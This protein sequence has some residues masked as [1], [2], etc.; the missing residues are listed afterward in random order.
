MIPTAAI[1][2]SNWTSAGHDI[3]NTRHQDSETEIST[4]TVGGLKVK[5]E[6]TTDGDVSATPAVDGSK[7]YFPD[8]A[9]YLSA[10]D[11]ETGK[12]VWKSSIATASGVAFD[13]AR[14]TPVIVGDKVIVGTQ[15]SILVPG[16]G[17]GGKLLAFNKNTGA[18]VWSTQLDSHP[19]AIITQSATA[20]GSRVYVGVASQEEALAGFVP[21]YPCCSFRGSMLSV[22]VQ[23]GAIVWKTYFVPSEPAG[24]SGN[25]IWGSSPAIDTKRNQVYVATGN[26]YSVPDSVLACV[27]AAAGN[28]TAIKACIAADS[29]FDAVVA[30]D[31]TSGAIRWATKALPF[32]AWTTSCLPPPFGDGSNCPQPEGPDY[33]FGQAPA[34]F[35]VEANGKPKQLVG[36]GQ[37]SGQYWAMNPD[38]GAVAWVTQAGPGGT[39]GGLQWGSAVDGKRV[40]TANANYNAVPWALPGGAVTNAGV[41]SALDAATGQLLW[42]KA[43][44]RPGFFFSAPEAARPVRSR[45]RTASSSV[46]RSAPSGICMRWMPPLAA[47]SGTSPLVAPAFPARPS[48]TARCSG[49]RVT[50]TSASVHST[51]SCTRSSSRRSTA[52]RQRSIRTMIVR[53]G[54]LAGC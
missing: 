30:L 27:E 10:V 18:L 48:R 9:G 32:D 24:Y 17:P 54:C 25:A 36:A 29:L 33:D 39:A 45:L 38:T 2:D 37:K 31:L 34:L 5:W 21:G 42:Q 13:K 26:N 51:T 8:W 40:Y 28:E 41:W 44:P 52:L 15:G 22:D 53:T 7:V 16:G 3:Q 1:A 4:S 12:L 49:A 20:Y 50:A 19:A 35:T 47:L 23:T 43:D 46:V 14:A 11:R 6:F